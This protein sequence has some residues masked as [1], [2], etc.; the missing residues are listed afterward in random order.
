MKKFV[1]ILL[2]VISLFG[3]AGCSTEKTY[4]IVTTMFPQYDFAQAIVGDK[5]SVGLI[6]P[7]GVEVHGFEATSQD[8][9]TIKESKLFIFTS[10]EIDTW[11]KDEATIGGDDT[12]VLNLSEHYTLSDHLHDEEHDHET[13]LN[14][15]LLN[16]THDDDD[17]DHDHEHDDQIH[18]WVDPTTAIQLIE[19]ILEHIILID[20]DNATFYE[21]NAHD[22]IHELEELHESIDLFFQNELYHEYTFY[23]AGHNALGAFASR[24]HFHIESL[25]PDFKPDAD[26]TS[27][28]LSAFINEIKANNV[29]YLFVEELVEP[30]AARTIQEALASED[31]TIILKELHGYHNITDTEL[32]AG[33]TYLDL[34]ERNFEYLKEALGAE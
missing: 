16:E 24:Y 6:L 28:E 21:E 27:S 7:P 26:L 4:D 30:K 23:F 12:L 29:T 25:F 32:E 3:I 14:G 15:I 18:Y 9:V 19:A 13:T 11:I 10:L 1:G 31:Y 22:Y 20:P 33:T 5:L 17:H 2:L 8:M 34:L